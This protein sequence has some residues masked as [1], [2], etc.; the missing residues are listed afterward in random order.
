M[1]NSAIKQIALVV[2][3]TLIAMAGVHAQTPCP[4]ASGDTTVSSSCDTGISLTG[5]NLTIGTPTSGLVEVSNPGNIV[6]KVIGTG[7]TIDNTVNGAI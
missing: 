3:S 7:N 1:I 5:A 2:G 4:D 6:I